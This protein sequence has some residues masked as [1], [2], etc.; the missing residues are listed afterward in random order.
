MRGAGGRRR[1]GGLV[2]VV[3]VAAMLAMT[4][5]PAA[6]Q[7]AVGPL[8]TAEQNP[9]YRLFHV[10]QPEPADVVGDGRFRVEISTAYSN[11]HEASRTASYRQLFDREQMTNAFAIRYGLGDALEVGGSVAVLTGWGGFL[12]PFVSGFHR[13]LGLPNGGREQEPEG[14]HVVRLEGR[15][16]SA[17]L[18]LPPTTLEREDVRLFT[19]WRVL[20]ASDAGG[21]LSL[22]ATVRRSAATPAPGRT[23]GAIAV[24]GR[25]SDG[26]LHAHGS[27]GATTLDPPPALE[28]VTQDIGVFFHAG[29]E[30]EIRS[31]LAFVGQF[32]GTSRY[33]EGFD[34]GELGRIPLTLA[35]GLAGQREDGWTWQVGFVEDVPPNSPSVDFTVHV[36]VGRNF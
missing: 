35:L 9:L 14:Q 33:V 19:K 18:E 21:A 11:I 8:R 25:I 2:R 24:L 30:R 22:R 15:D 10:P 27:V 29:L 7:D 3:C 1:T 36:E 5:V 28:A 20:G 12:D 17:M 31:G 26:P 6:A 13:A 23:A 16:S 34:R 4:A 32:G